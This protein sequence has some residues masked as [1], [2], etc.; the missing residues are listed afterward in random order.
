MAAPSKC[1][2]AGRKRGSGQISGYSLVPGGVLGRHQLEAISAAR[3]GKEVAVALAPAALG[4][5]SS[6]S[7]PANLLVINTMTG[8]RAVWHGGAK[9]FSAGDLTFTDN[10][11]ALEFLGITRCPQA[12]R[13]GCEELR[14]MSPATAGGQLDSSRLLLRM[15]ALARSPGEYIEPVII[16]TGGSAGRSTRSCP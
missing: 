10:G 6:P 12:K 2:A 9:V 8:A 1:H 13:S 4:E 5:F 7:A 14:A 15:S 3:D 16:T 11:R